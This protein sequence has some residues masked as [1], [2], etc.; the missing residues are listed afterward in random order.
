MNVD[1]RRAAAYVVCRDENDRLLLTRLRTAGFPSDGMWTMPGGG[2]DV[3]E[4]PE[5]TAV[6]ELHEETGLTA[7]MGP[8]LGMFS[9]WFTAEES[10]RNKPG[11]SIAPVYLAQNL[12]GELREHFE[13][14]GSTDAAQWFTLEEIRS[15]PRVEL[16]DFVLDLL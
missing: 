6:R 4:T 13:E 8:I 1:W 11:H 7:T 2:M 15:L 5:Q 10:W 12:S 9:S 3:G 16:V 14:E